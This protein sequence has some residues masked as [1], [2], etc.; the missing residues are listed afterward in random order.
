MSDLVTKATKAAMIAL[1]AAAGVTHPR[2]KQRQ[3]QQQQQQGANKG[4][5]ATNQRVTDAAAWI[6]AAACATATASHAATAIAA[7]AAVS[8]TAG[9][10]RG[11]SSSSSGVHVVPL[12]QAYPADGVLRPLAEKVLQP[13]LA[14]SAAATAS[15]GQCFTAAVL[16]YVMRHKWMPEI[17][18][19]SN[20]LVPFLCRQPQEDNKQ[21]S[22]VWQPREGC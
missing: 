11:G 8:A 2:H 6:L 9:E 1:E 7:A 16:R 5:R 12:L 19:L 14:G 13:G 10:G 15:G 4:F 3:Q 21:T 22:V 18:A 17:V 20:A